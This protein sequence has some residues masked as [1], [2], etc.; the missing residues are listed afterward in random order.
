MLKMT[1]LRRQFAGA[2]IGCLAAAWSGSLSSACAQSASVSAWNAANFRSW[3]FIPYWISPTEVTSFGTD[4]VYE[5]V[6]DVVYHSGVQPR[7]DGSLFTGSTAATLR[8]RTQQRR[9]GGASRRAGL[10]RDYQ[11]PDDANHLHQQRRKCS[12]V[13]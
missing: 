10:E 13:E 12:R 9:N 11:Q 2:L 4:R 1:F 3:S 6:S 7:A 8:R 5:H